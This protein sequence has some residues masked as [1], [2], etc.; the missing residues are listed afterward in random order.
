MDPARSFVLSFRTGFAWGQLRTLCGRR[1]ATRAALRRPAPG[2]ATFSHWLGIKDGS[3]SREDGRY[4]V[5]H[6]SAFDLLVASF[7]RPR[8]RVRLR[9]KVE[10]REGARQNQLTSE[11]RADPLQ[12]EDR[13]R[14]LRVQ[15]CWVAVRHIS[16]GISASIPSATVSST[17]R[18]TATIRAPQGHDCAGRHAQTV[19]QPAPTIQSS[20]TAGNCCHHNSRTRNERQ[21]WGEK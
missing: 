4:A 12:E 9:G 6:A 10:L 3:E 2:H 1:L 14:R 20:R 21:P 11:S 16:A 13:P 18:D 19:Q 7:T 15:G 17:C 8:S 5:W